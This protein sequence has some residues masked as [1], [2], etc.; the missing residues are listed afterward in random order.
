MYTAVVST[1][2]IPR[3]TVCICTYKRTRLL[4]AL[5]KAL[6]DQI[7]E[8][9]FALDVVVVDNDREASAAT[10]TE[11]FAA[12]SRLTVIY[13][14][15]PKQGIALARNLAVANATG[16]FVAFIDDDEF[17]PPQWLAT[18]FKTCVTRSVDGVLGPVQPHIEAGT[19]QWVIKGNFYNRPTYPT[20][21]V[22]DWR[23]GRTGNVLFKRHVFARSSVPF[24]AE[25]RAGE[26]QD[27]FR[28]AIES[29]FVFIWCNEAVVCESVP[30]VRWKRR[31]M[32]RR[33]LLR[34]AMARL[35]PSCGFFSIAKSLFAV[36]VYTIELPFAL[37]FGQHR[38][39]RLLVRLCDHL[40]KILAVAGITVIQ[41][42][43]VTE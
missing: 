27:F 3:I 8:S 25:F 32:L 11:Q 22:I 42:P 28:R 31:V 36:V 7:T 35:Q 40:G 4:A 18:L 39:M 33:A 16:D 6:D 19:P 37:V 1:P 30:P 38:F 15:E 12:S 14:V 20:G 2:C 26:D 23:K 24:R 41:E 10:V 17:P 13:R 29:G 5:L 43:Y 34:G 9:L 21:L